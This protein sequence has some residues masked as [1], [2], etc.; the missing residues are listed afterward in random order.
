MA[1]EPYLAR[2]AG[3][4]PGVSGQLT[5]YGFEVVHDFLIGQ[6]VPQAGAQQA[7]RAPGSDMRWQAPDRNVDGTAARRRLTCPAGIPARGDAVHRRAEA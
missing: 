4:A 3:V 5:H 6:V 2:P 7:P 1:H